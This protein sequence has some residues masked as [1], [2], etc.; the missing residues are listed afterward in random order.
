MYDF[1]K[2]WEASKTTPEAKKIVALEFLQPAIAKLQKT[3][4][5]LR[6][7]DAGCGDG[8]HAEVLNGLNLDHH[9]LGVDISNSALESAKKKNLSRWNFEISNLGKLPYEDD[10]FDISISFGV[11][12][13]TND[14]RRSFSELC[15]VTK[16]GGLIGI[17]VYPK[18]EDLGIYFL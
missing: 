4:N 11:I 5:K 6:I 15:R 7:L 16:K 18:R 3:V 12:N 17:W 8:V 13:Y 10:T 14:P 2:H 9:F 1:Q